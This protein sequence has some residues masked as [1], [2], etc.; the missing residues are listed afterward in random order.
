MFLIASS[1]AIWRISRREVVDHT[2]V[3]DGGPVDTEG[4][5]QPEPAGVVT[6]AMAAVSPPPTG[7][8]EELAATLPAPAT[9]PDPKAPSAATT[10]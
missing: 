3:V 2:N 1:F 6:T 8:T 7:A 10:V 4:P 9:T 5:G